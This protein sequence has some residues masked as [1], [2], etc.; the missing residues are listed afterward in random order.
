MRNCNRNLIIAFFQKHYYNHH[1]RLLPVSGGHITSPHS[2]HYFPPFPSPQPFSS[3]NIQSWKSSPP[4]AGSL[5]RILDTALHI[6][7]LA[8]EPAFVLS[9]CSSRPCTSGISLSVAVVTRAGH[10]CW[11]L[12]YC[13]VVADPFCWFKVE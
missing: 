3:S 1:I 5:G 9:S 8:M 7:L 13:F 4:G 11:Y 10:P 2:L 6:Q 12:L